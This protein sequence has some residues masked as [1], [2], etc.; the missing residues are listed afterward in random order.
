LD[1][2]LGLPEGKNSY[3]LQD[4]DQHQ[5]VEQPYATVSATLGPNPRFHPIG[6]HPG[7]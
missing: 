5:V 3:L 7:T 2:R 6:A 4:W 1:Q